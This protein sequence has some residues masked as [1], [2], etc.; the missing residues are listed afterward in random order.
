[1]GEFSQGRLLLVLDTL[2]QP[3]YKII[4]NVHPEEAKFMRGPTAFM[5]GHQDNTA[6][7]FRE[8]PR[9]ARLSRIAWNVWLLELALK[10]SKAKIR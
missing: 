4:R 7:F 1:M 3:K 8:N 2:E 9:P 6:K 10:R 5:S